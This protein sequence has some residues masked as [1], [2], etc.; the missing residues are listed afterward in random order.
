[1]GKRIMNICP[2][3]H[4]KR[5]VGLCKGTR[6]C[7]GCQDDYLE[8]Y[9]PKYTKTHK[10]EKRAYDKAHLKEKRFRQQERRKWINSLKAFPCTDCKISYPPYVMQFDHLRNKEFQIGEVW[11][12]KESILK[13]IA[14]CELVCANCHMER[15]HHGHKNS[16][17]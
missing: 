16:L 12:S 9:L 10:K 4:D 17:S 13:E 5:L 15:T 11:R 7:K 2:K 6:K 14:K 3:G 1:M 8:I